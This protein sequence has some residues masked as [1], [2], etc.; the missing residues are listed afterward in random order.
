MHRHVVVQKTEQLS[1]FSFRYGNN[2][3]LAHS[4]SVDSSGAC[5]CPIVRPG[6]KIQRKREGNLL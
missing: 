6:S 2:R 3:N 1:Y 5:Y 4:V